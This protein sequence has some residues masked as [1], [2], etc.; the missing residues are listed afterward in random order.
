MEKYIIKAVGPKFSAFNAET[1]EVFTYVN[2]KGF[3]RQEWDSERGV[4]RQLSA[5]GHDYPGKG[6]SS[7]GVRHL[8]TEVVREL[9]EGGNTPE[10][11]AK[12]KELGTTY[13]LVKRRY[14]AEKYAA[15]SEEERAAQKERR[16]GYAERAKE[17][18]ARREE[19]AA[20][21]SEEAQEKR[22][23]GKRAFDPVAANAFIRAFKG[24]EKDNTRKVQR[25][26][27]AGNQTAQAILPT[28][29]KVG[30]GD[31]TIEA[32]LTQHGKGA[33]TPET[34]APSVKETESDADALAALKAE[35]AA[36][37]QR[38]AALS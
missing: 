34:P 14:Y 25:K 37:T 9:F 38:I 11:E 13:F 22:A 35:L 31:L 4:K 8:S 27:A 24:F 15:M 16:A 32:A 6:K 12:C 5:S 19:R 3:S 23:E 33:K 10:N 1:G 18:A 2:T 28:A 20:D 29:R 17:R 7:I 21:M 30:W 26:A 36:L